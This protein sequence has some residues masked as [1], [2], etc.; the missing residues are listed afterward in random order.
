MKKR[1]QPTIEDVE[2]LVRKE[3]PDYRVSGRVRIAEGR[4]VTYD[5]SIEPKPSTPAA[6]QD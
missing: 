6:P 4:I 1:K 2:R 3:F 5:R